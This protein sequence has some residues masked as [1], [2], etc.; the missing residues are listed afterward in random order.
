MPVVC[1][2]CSRN[3]PEYRR[4]CLYCG[5][6][7]NVRSCPRCSRPNNPA[8]PG[9]IYCGAEL[10]PAGHPY[11]RGDARA[12]SN[13]KPELVS[14]PGCGRGNRPG[15]ST[16]LYCGAELPDGG[17]RPAAVAPG[18]RHRVECD[19]CGQLSFW[20]AETVRKMLQARQSACLR[21][22]GRLQMPEELEALFRS[23]LWRKGGV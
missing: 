15:S 14:C 13:H 1:P 12:T 16:C 7:F 18:R 21:C 19:S 20:D 6:P 17:G 11:R 10:A 5:E 4:S 23:V 9:C 8:S 22:G 3:N 2:A